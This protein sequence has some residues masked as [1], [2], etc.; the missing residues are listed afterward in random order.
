MKYSG[1]SGTPRQ[2][3]DLPKISLFY[4]WFVVC[5]MVVPYKMLV[6]RHLRIYLRFIEVE[7]EKPLAV[8]IVM[9]MCTLSLH[10]RYPVTHFGGDSSATSA[11]R[12]LSMTSHV[13]GRVCLTVFGAKYPS[14]FPLTSCPYAS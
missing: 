2:C 7:I 11:S 1:A 14:C 13:L 8:V 10:V 6:L 9:N 4:G 12:R 5:T 3:E